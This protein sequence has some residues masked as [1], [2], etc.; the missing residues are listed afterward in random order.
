MENLYTYEII[1]VD[2]QARCMEVI[3]SATGHPT[4]HIGARL[5]YEGETLDA[6][7]QMYA[8]IRYWEEL[9]QTVVVPEVGTS[10][11]VAPPPPPA[12]VIPP[13]D[14]INISITDL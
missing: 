8:P 14:V 12:E 9:T 13:S 4:M 2:A 11:T 10:G 1:S 7:I 5:P 3:Y 6:V